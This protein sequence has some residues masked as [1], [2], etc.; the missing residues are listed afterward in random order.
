MTQCGYSQT[1]SAHAHRHTEA[2]HTGSATPCLSFMRLLFKTS[3]ASLTCV[4]VDEVETLS[5]LAREYFV[6]RN[7]HLLAFFVLP[8]AR[9]LDLAAR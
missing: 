4:K 5:N 7:G 6:K 2:H 9:E 3:A 1:L 8:V